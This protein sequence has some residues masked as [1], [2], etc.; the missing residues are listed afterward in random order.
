MIYA[1]EPAQL[2]RIKIRMMLT[3]FLVSFFL[4][5]YFCVVV[6]HGNV[7]FPRNRSHKIGE[8]GHISSAIAQVHSVNSQFG[9]IRMNVIKYNSWCGQLV[10]YFVYKYSCYCSF[11]VVVV[12]FVIFAACTTNRAL[13]HTHIHSTIV[14]VLAAE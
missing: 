10:K 7:H 12:V 4:F 8:C 2:D 3:A 6:Y 14:C 9:E 1:C 5:E 11:V 13:T